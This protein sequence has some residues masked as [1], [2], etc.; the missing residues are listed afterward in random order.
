MFAEEFAV[1][2][3]YSV[4]NTISA[5]ELVVIPALSDAS[6]LF[7]LPRSSGNFSSALSPCIASHQL[8]KIVG[9][10]CR[11]RLVSGLET[12]KRALIDVVLC[13]LNEFVKENFQSFNNSLL[14][15]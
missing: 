15:H 7:P 3:L 6:R 8:K 14:S 10:R 4:L 11:L 5:C 13:Q 1:S 2:L 9:S 12:L